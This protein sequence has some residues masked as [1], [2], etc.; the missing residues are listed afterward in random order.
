MVIQNWST[1][2]FDA[3]RAMESNHIGAVIVQESG[4][5]VG[6]VSDRDLALRVIG[7]DLDPRAALLH[8][9]MTPDPATLSITDSEELAARL[10]RIHHVRRVPI[11]NGGVAVGIVTLDDLILS[12]Q[13][14]L[15]TLAEIVKV[16]LAEPAASKPAGFIHP[17]RR[18]RPAPRDSQA[19]DGRYPK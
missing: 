17:T 7:S 1:T 5:V 6:I 3:V 15:A 11:S 14:D 9:V 8:D 10:M 18:P 2:A 16:Q 19:D 4:R 12:G 13:I